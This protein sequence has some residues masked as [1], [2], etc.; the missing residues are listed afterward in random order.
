MFVFVCLYVVWCLCVCVVVFVC[1]L[2]CVCG[3]CVC[4][5]WGFLCVSKKHNAN[6]F[7]VQTDQNVSV[8]VMYTIKSSDAQRILITPYNEKFKAFEKS[9]NGKCFLKFY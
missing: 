5:W 2:W 9:W 6:I 8:H 1:V 7:E 4:Q 3:V